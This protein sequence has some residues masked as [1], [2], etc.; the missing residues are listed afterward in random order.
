MT[1]T[2]IVDRLAE[3]KT[4]S[5]APREELAWLAAHGSVRHLAAGDVL[6]SKGATVEGMFI[7]L[8]GHIAIFVDRGAGRHKMMEWRGGEIAGLLPYSRLV[9][10]PADSVAQEPS[11]VLA[12][13]RDRMPEMIRECHAIT[14]LLVH[15]M[16]DRARAFTSSDLHDEKMVSLGKLSAGLAHELNNPASAIERGA[17]LMESR[18][19]ETEQATRALGAARLT[20]EQ[21]AAV[22][23][24]RTACL[25]KQAQGVLSPIEQADREDAIADW[26]SDHGL[27]VASAEALA[28]TKVTFA[29]LDALAEAVSGPALD[30][31]L[32]WAAAG[33]AV[34]DLAAEIQEAATR[35]SGLVAAIK[36]FT[37]MDQAKAAAPVDLGRSLS[38]TIAVLGAKARG[39]SVAVALRVEPGLPRALGLAGELNQVWANL[40]DNALDA[41]AAVAVIAAGRVEVL[42]SREQDRVVVRIVDN[43]PG[44]PAEVRARMFDPFFTTKP[45]GQGT[46]LGLDIVRRLVQH[47]DGEIAVETEPG[48]TEFRVTLP[49]V[50]EDEPGG[51]Q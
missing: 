6:S 27:D 22:D 42:A 1:E 33:C 40:I 24:V 44:I 32:R 34:R 12:V 11:T 8:S 26:L 46:G 19:Q 43:G 29:A 5:G 10:P 7:V 31:V 21:L 47:N 45:M 9:S 23:A 3:H 25:S 51:A 38:N 4:L 37:H 13:S 39:K 49:L 17:A 36:G 35:I 28:E 14:S 20:D 2:E 48:R 16:V 41:V 18:L 15:T 50:I 30:A